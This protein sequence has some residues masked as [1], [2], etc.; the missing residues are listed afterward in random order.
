MKT[1]K[2][3]IA[4]AILAFSSVASAALVDL[5]I[6]FAGIRGGSLDGVTG[7]DATGT[8]I[9]IDVM[10]IA[11]A[12]FNGGAVAEYEVTNGAL[13]FDTA[14]NTFV[15]SGTVTIDNTVV[16][17]TLF[18]GGMVSA[19]FT[20]GLFDVFQ[21]DGSGVMSNSLLTAIGEPVS[22]NPFAFV[23][24][25]LESR[26]GTLNSTDVLSTSI[27]PR[28]PEVPIPAAVWLFGSGLI[29]LVGVARRK[30]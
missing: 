4:G 8:N 24:F 20:S 27:G 1:F 12:E 19:S 15:I 22:S 30:V 7:G 25:S 21:T 29:G 26:D 16:S 18:D 2:I 14:A 9:G 17:G 13:N 11:G 5:N 6:D 28:T 23:G 10:S 3:L